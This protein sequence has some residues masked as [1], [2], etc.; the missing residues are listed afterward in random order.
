MTDRF[1]GRFDH[2]VILVPDLAAAQKTYERL[3][4]SVSPGGRHEGLGTHNALIR[5]GVD[6]LELLA[7]HD[8]EMAIATD[9]GK[10]LVDLIESGRGGLASFALATAQIEKD[11]ERFARTGL[12]AVGP[13]AMKRMRPDAKLLSWRLLVPHGSSWRVRWPFFIQWDQSDETRLSWERSGGHSNGASKVVGASVAV[14][15]LDAAGD[16]Y[17]RKLG[18]AISPA[19]SAPEIGAQR[20]VARVGAFEISLCAPAGEGA[21]ARRLSDA[22]EGIYELV[23]ATTGTPRAI[24]ASDALGARLVLRQA[25]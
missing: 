3:G 15:D 13:F 24:E 25:A 6:Y 17:E 1:H 20:R 8:R 14:K 4:F 11:A 22:G 16:L 23:I 9:R 2:A 12:P 18:I 21:I 5:F 7:V 19:E 10:A